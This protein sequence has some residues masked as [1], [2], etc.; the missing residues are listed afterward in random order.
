M[1][2]IRERVTIGMPAAPPSRWYDARLDPLPAFVAGGPQNPMG[3][4]TP[5]EPPTDSV[6]TRLNAMADAIKSVCPDPNN[7][8]ASLSDERRAAATS[9]N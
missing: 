4:R 8:Y 3:A 6:E 2:N 9:D 7:F 5:A 1:I